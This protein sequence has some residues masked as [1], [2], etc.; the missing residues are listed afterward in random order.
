MGIFDRI[1][2]S[3]KKNVNTQPDSSDMSF[4]NSEEKGSGKIISV[5][6]QK[7]GV[8]KTSL[9]FNLAHAL[10]QKNNK[11]LLIDF[12]P[13]FNLST[14]VL[15]DLPNEDE[16]VFQLLINSV[17]QL[18]TLH[19]PTML[20]E[21]I[22]SI[23]P[24]IDIISGGQMLSGFELTVGGINSV[25]QTIL[26]KFFEHHQLKGMY[27]Y[28]LIDGPPT[29]G[30]LVVNILCASDGVIIPFIPDAF[31]QTGIRNLETVINDIDE[32]GL[33]CTPEILGLIPN[34]FDKRR[35]FARN[36]LENIKKELNNFTFFPEIENKVDL[37]KAMG[38]KRSVFS[39]KSKEY[40]DIKNKFSHI[41]DYLL[42]K[43][44]YEKEKP[45]L[46][47]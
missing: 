31:C 30:L 1:S 41:A 34:L 33:G 40:N 16:Q 44:K 42:E 6:N 25:R 11:V 18:K 4:R 22:K 35:K 13:Q 7:G 17:K 15:N 8:G 5:I 20:S 32:M 37:F 3:V 9:C 47:S 21:A 27:D 43:Y 19:S 2:E 28:I 29:L 14:V 46:H 12:D 39:F 26:K 45:S 36:E 23:N 10:A 24:F 38:E